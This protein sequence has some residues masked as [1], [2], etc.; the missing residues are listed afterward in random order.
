MVNIGIALFVLIEDDN[1]SAAFVFIILKYEDM[2]Y[3]RCKEVFQ[4][5][6]ILHNSTY[7][8]KRNL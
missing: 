8:Y 3:W 1:R 7:L 2:N 5:L 4:L 6:V